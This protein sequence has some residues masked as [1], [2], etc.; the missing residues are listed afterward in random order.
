MSNRNDYD[1]E[2]RYE[3]E[4][5]SENELIHV[6]P[7]DDTF[8]GMPIEHITSVE[9]S[10]KPT[11]DYDDYG[12]PIALHHSWD[13]RE[14][15]EPDHDKRDC[16]FCQTRIELEINRHLHKFNGGRYDETGE[17]YNDGTKV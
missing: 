12:A 1:E 2:D 15:D 5:E 8:F 3:A 10:C 6:T 11:L 13:L 17:Y 14:H 16:Q 9:C 4:Q 7:I